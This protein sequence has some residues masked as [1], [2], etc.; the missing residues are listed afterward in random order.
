[1]Q[2]TPTMPTPILSVQEPVGPDDEQRRREQ[3]IKRIREKNAFKIH[4]V[5][6]LVVNAWF[7][8]LWAIT[9]AGYFW[10]IF[11]MLAWGTGLVIHGYTAYHGETI[12]EEQ[13]E[14]EMKRLL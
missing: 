13:I 10:P 8:V 5:A 2:T 4:L 1:M 14:R 12:T 9:G 7:V 3:A 6:Y 11:V